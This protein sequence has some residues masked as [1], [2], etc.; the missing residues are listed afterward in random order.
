MAN[1]IYL[2]LIATMFPVTLS[3]SCDNR[4][5][6]QYI[7]KVD[8]S[9]STFLTELNDIVTISSPG[10]NISS[11]NTLR[12]LYST[13]VHSF[14]LT[15]TSD[16]FD[17]FSMALDTIL[18][19]Y[20]RACYGADDE[21]P[22]KA[23]APRLLSQFLF[24]LENH[25]NITTIRKLY[26]QLS[27]LKDFSNNKELTKRQTGNRLSECASKPTIRELYDCLEPD[28]LS[29]IFHLE[30][31][32]ARAMA[33]NQGI[34]R[35]FPD[36]SDCVGFVVDTTGSMSDEIESVKEVIQNFTASE[37]DTLTLCYTLVPFNDFGDYSAPLE[38][39]KIYICYDAMLL[40]SNI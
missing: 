38:D 36:P 13:L 2:V 33:S 9:T 25:T 5:V 34:I 35:T 6:A 11:N 22:T 32:C 40:H 29:C 18:E 4:F 12:D 3:L 14:N 10:A 24:L 16:G 20:F 23:D 17:N 15:G 7:Q 31:D 19:S 30:R 27:C 37:Q 28:D 39:S 21:R 1:L 26:G 8:N